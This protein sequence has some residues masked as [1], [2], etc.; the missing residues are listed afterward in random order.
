MIAY[1]RNDQGTGICG[2]FGNGKIAISVGNSGQTGAFHTNEG[3]RQGFPCFGIS[4]HTIYRKV[5]QAGLVQVNF[6]LFG[7]EDDLAVQHLV[8]DTL[9]GK[10][11]IEK[12]GQL[13][14]AIAA[15]DGDAGYQRIIKNYFDIVLIP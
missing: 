5:E 4:H 11:A 7:N 15:I 9:L 12:V 8:I 10:N 13:H 14:I 6:Y 3:I 2:Y 1:I